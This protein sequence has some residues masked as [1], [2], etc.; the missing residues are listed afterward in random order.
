MNDANRAA[1]SEALCI[2][3]AH[4]LA[5]AAEISMASSPLE[6]AMLADRLNTID[7]GRIVLEQMI[8]NFGNSTSI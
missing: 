8:A 4:M 5:V 6:T 7:N 2:V 1:C 3:E